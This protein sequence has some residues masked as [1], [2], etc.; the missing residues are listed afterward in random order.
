MPRRGRNRRGRGSNN[1]G[2][3]DG[4]DN[5]DDNNGGYQNRHGS[6]DRN[7]NGDQN[8]GGPNNG[9]QG[10]NG[11]QSGGPGHRNNGNPGNNRD[12]N[13]NGGHQNNRGNQHHNGPGNRWRDNRHEPLSEYIMFL[14]VEDRFSVEK[15]REMVSAAAVMLDLSWEKMTA[16]GKSEAEIARYLGVPSKA[17]RTLSQL[18][19]KLLDPANAVPDAGPDADGDIPMLDAGGPGFNGPNMMHLLDVGGLNTDPRNVEPELYVWK[20][21]ADGFRNNS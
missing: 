18:S 6:G 8:G 5:N 15:V 12:G 19:Q 7:S 3:G 13:Q 11:S 16:A 21:L 2:N 4:N 20:S 9:S 10:S 1:A 14:L 17:C